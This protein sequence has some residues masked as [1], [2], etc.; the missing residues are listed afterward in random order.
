MVALKVE[1]MVVYWAVELQVKVEVD[2]VGV[3]VEAEWVAG[4]SDKEGVNLGEVE[5]EE[6]KEEETEEEDMEEEGKGEVVMEVHYDNSHYMY[7]HKL[8]SAFHKLFC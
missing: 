6:E 5:K 8:H 1:I 7:F 2:V 3:M 4:N